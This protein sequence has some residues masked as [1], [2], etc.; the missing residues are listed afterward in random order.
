MCICGKFLR[1]FLNLVVSQDQRSCIQ[2]VQ[3]SYGTYCDRDG[4]HSRGLSVSG[5]VCFSTLTISFKGSISYTDLISQKSSNVQIVNGASVIVW[6]GVVG[7]PRNPLMRIMCDNSNALVRSVVK[8]SYGITQCYMPPDRGD[9]HTFTPAYCRY[10]FI[11]PGRMK[12]WV[13]LGGWLY[14]DRLPTDGHP[15][16]Y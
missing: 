10:S 12:G 15:F 13:D 9:S 1:Q 2:A 3:C 11:D 14:Q 4:R 7:A 6:W 16:N 5:T 8:L